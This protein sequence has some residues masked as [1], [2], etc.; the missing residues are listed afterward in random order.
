MA[1]ETYT[2]QMIIKRSKGYHVDLIFR[3]IK[4]VS[5]VIDDCLAG[6]VLTHYH[7][8]YPHAYL[9][10]MYM[11]EVAICKILADPVNRI[12]ELKAKTML[13]PKNLQDAII[14]YF[15]LES[16]FIC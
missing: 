9:N 11:G 4:R 7:V 16:S 3:D 5:R 6:S 12:A 15:L 2:R 10:A 13:Y 1:E 8:G 14:G